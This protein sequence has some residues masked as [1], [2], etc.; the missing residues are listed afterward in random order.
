MI[1]LLGVEVDWG[2]VFVGLGA[3]LAGAGS[4]LSG[5]AALKAA[6]KGGTKNGDKQVSSPP[7][8]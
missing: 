8:G 5:I 2:R 3:F 1:Y 6:R 7:N 4:V